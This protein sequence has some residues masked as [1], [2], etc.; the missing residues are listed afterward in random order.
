MGANVATAFFYQNKE[1]FVMEREQEKSN[2][3]MSEQDKRRWRSYIGLTG[4]LIAII[5]IILQDFISS[6][7][8]DIAT[9]IA[10]I[11]FALALPLLALNIFILQI[12]LDYNFYL[13]SKVMLAILALSYLFAVT[14]LVATFWHIAWFVGL[15]F[16]SASIFVIVI[17]LIFIVKIDP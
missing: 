13:T 8:S 5:L 4:G 3:D 6:G 10:V 9:L 14:G 2:N 11:S 15:I 16:L 17:G 1:G 12:T 7:I